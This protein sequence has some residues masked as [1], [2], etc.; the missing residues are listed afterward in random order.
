MH[1]QKE[2]E[3]ELKTMGEVEEI[4]GQTKNQTKRPMGKGYTNQ[5]KEKHEME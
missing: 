4:D 5:S 3:R 1:K 2:M